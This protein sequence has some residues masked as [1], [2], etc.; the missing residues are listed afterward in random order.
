[1]IGTEGHIT[2]LSY[3]YYHINR[4]LTN[5][6]CKNCPKIK[7]FKITIDDKDEATY[8]DLEKILIRCQYLEVYIFKEIILILIYFRKY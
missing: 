5:T 4:K 6:I 3:N 7:Y 2:E 1:M 8:Y